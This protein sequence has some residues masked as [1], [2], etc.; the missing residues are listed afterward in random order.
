MNRT[1]VARDESETKL[2]HELMG[3][4]A[5]EAAVAATEAEVAGGPSKEQMQIVPFV[6]ESPS[7]TAPTKYSMTPAKFWQ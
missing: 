1:L 7:K 4:A 2:L 5:S 3:A 6:A